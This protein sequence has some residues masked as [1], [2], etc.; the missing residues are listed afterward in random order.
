[1]VSCSYLAIVCLIAKCVG[2]A[3]NLSREDSFALLFSKVIKKAAFIIIVV[4]AYSSTIRSLIVVG[5][6]L[7]VAVKPGTDITLLQSLLPLILTSISS[8]STL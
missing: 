2:T 7:G 4:S 3:N 1:M 8:S 6:K 5:Y